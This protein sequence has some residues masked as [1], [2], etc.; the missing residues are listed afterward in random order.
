MTG[1]PLNHVRGNIDDSLRARDG[2]DLLQKPRRSQ[3]LHPQRIPRHDPCGRSIRMSTTL[4]H[5]LRDVG[6]HSSS[7]T[8]GLGVSPGHAFVCLAQNDVIGAG[9][10]GY[11]LRGSP[12]TSSTSTGG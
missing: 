3:R 6:I 1:F 2:V 4:P 11:L 9:S 7:E 8:R 10:I 5:H 12:T